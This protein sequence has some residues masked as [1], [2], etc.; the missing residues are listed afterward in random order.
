MKFLGSWVVPNEGIV[1]VNI[2]QHFFAEQLGSDWCTGTRIDTASK[3]V[4]WPE[5]KMLIKD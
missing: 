2:L 1:S 4:L 3:A 5:L